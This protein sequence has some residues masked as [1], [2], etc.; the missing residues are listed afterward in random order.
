[1]TELEQLKKRIND[2]KLNGVETAHIRNDYEPAGDMMIA[3]LTNSG[4]Y[5]QRRAPAHSFNSEWRIFRKGFEP[6]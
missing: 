5:V 2:S 3:N 4:E 1:M 6:Y